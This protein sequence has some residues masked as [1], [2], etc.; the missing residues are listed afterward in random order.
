VQPT[1]AAESREQ[2][3]R[4]PS[5]RGGIIN[6]LILQGNHTDLASADRSTSMKEIDDATLQSLKAQADEAAKPVADQAAE[7][8]YDAAYKEAYEDVLDDLRLQA[9][10]VAKQ[11]GKDAYDAAYKIA[12][13][14]RLAELIKE[15]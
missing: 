7:A 14:Q 1:N 8:A 11:V 13:E 12:Y 6:E 9:E 5:A 15:L 3:K 2:A 10:E 4:N